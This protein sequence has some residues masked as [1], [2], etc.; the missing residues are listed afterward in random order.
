VLCRPAID[1]RQ[2]DV[3]VLDPLK[4]FHGVQENA[5]DQM[6]EVMTILSEIAMEK[7]ISIEILH[8]TRKPSA[9]AGGVAMTVDDGRGADAIIA[10]ARS[11]R[12]VNGLAPK[13][14]AAL[15]VTESEAWRHTRIDNGKANM[16]P[17][18]KAAWTYSASVPL[19][20]GESVG[21]FE[22]WKPPDTFEGMSV[23]D[24][25]F[26]RE[27]AQGGA[28]R[29]DVQAKAD[30]IGE[31]LADRLGLDLS[32]KEDRARVNRIIKKWMQTKVL[33][34]EERLDETRRKRKYIVPG[35]WTDVSDDA[36]CSTF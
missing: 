2:I 12:I 18:G 7:N 22:A 16:A 3:L 34:T 14:A 32:Q 30:W 10:G 24:I 25:N 13:E 19:P 20:C 28:Y 31:P 1:D 35:K 4:K 36:A 17:P 6:D 8:H 11:A 9:G 27:V 33:D 21:V 23:A 15:G 5:N 29:A 26:I